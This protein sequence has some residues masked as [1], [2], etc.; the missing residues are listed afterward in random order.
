MFQKKFFILDIEEAHELNT[1]KVNELST[2]LGIF[3]SNKNKHE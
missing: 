2:P 1:P 3:F